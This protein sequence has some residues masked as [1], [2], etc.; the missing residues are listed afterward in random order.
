M[1]VSAERISH[2]SLF[3]FLTTLECMEIAQ[4][5]DYQ[6]FS[7]K[8]TILRG[9]SGLPGIIFLDSG[10]LQESEFADDGRVIGMRILNPGEAYGLHYLID[11]R[12]SQS[13]LRAIEPTGLFIWTMGHARKKIFENTFLMQAVIKE[14]TNKIFLYHKEK[15]LLNIP[16]SYHRVFLHLHLLSTGLGDGKKIAN[17][18]N[19]KD[20]AS[21]VNTSRE[22]VS[23]AL[24]ILIRNGI[25]NKNG[26]QLYVQNMR[27]LTKLAIDGMDGLVGEA[28]AK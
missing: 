14:L 8:E 28:N 22:T 13:N 21:A 4:F 27:L 16:N 5:V 11:N 18:P 9:R 7:S 2:F 17:L 3:K 6:K 19:Q 23:R 1:A 12:Q 15:S 25:L 20:I 10:Q 26:H 24:Q